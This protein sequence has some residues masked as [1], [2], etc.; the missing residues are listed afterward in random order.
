MQFS[1]NHC[2]CRHG[3]DAAIGF[4]PTGWTYQTKTQSFPVHEKPP[5]K[6]HLIPYSEH[7]SFTELQEFVGFLRPRKVVPT[8]GVSGDRGDANAHKLASYFRHLCDNS[9]AIRSF[10][11]PM[12]AKAAPSSDGD[13][14][15]PHEKQL[16]VTDAVEKAETDCTDMPVNKEPSKPEVQDSTV[17]EPDAVASE[18]Q[19][20]PH[21]TGL[22][23]G[24]GSGPVASCIK[25]TGL[26]NA[27]VRF[28]C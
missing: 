10:I 27:D 23:T 6:V 8:V 2:L 26:H 12:I 5:W 21:T 16:I 25:G 28:Q 14:T 18:L 13:P 3:A 19:K 1:E 17:P 9:G 15:I 7:S 11:G 4:V 22:D 20:Y 24:C